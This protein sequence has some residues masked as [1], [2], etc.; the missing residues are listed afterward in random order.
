MRETR[1]PCHS[2]GVISLRF[3]SELAASPE[4]V[5]TW[6]TSLRGISTELSPIMKMTAPRSVETL[7]DVSVDFGTPLFRSWILLFGVIPID[8]SDLTLM[9]MDVGRGFVE[10]SPMLSMT[11]WR[12][13]RT[14]SNRA[15]KTVLTDELTFEP[16]FA[17]RLVE[18]FIR[19]TFRHRHAVVRRTLGTAAPNDGRRHQPRQ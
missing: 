5:W 6:I 18:W 10:E 12:H 4:R 8:R 17:P 14:I 16:R 2:R 7:A 1:P 11:L 19:T 15:G 13:A 9:S 3:E